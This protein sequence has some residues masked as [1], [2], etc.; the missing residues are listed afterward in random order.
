M[1]RLEPIKR[2]DS[3]AFYA[4]FLDVDTNEALTGIAGMLQCQARD[5][6]DVLH[7]TFTVVETATAG[8]YLFTAPSTSN[9]PINKF[10]YIDLQYTQGT[11]VVSSETFGVYVEGDITHG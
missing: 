10:L 4:S 6:T 1:L 2:G 11:T 8:T 5:S 3:F 9:L 7:I